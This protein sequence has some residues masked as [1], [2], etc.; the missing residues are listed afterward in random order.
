M[1]VRNP[2]L[3]EMRSGLGLESLEIQN[4][5]CCH[6]RIKMS[7]DHSLPPSS[8]SSTARLPPDHTVLAQHPSIP[9]PNPNPSPD[10]AAKT[11]VIPAMDRNSVKNVPVNHPRLRRGNSIRQ[12]LRQGSHLARRKS[13]GFPRSNSIASIAD[14]SSAV[15]WTNLVNPRKSLVCRSSSSFWEPSLELSCPKSAG[16][17]GQ[18]A[19]QHA[20]ETKF[21][22]L[23]IVPIEIILEILEHLDGACA[24]FSSL[25]GHPIRPSRLLPFHPTPPQKIKLIPQQKIHIA[26]TLHRLSISS[27]HFRD[28]VSSSPLA[29]FNQYR[30][31]VDDLTTNNDWRFGFTGG[32]QFINDKSQFLHVLSGTLHGR[33]S[34]DEAMNQRQQ[35]IELDGVRNIENTSK[36]VKL[37][38]AN[39]WK[40]CHFDLDLQI[41]PRLTLRARRFN[42]STQT[43]FITTPAPAAFATPISP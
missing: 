9:I 8:S 14:S 17:F 2:R 11:P 26:E 16:N 33:E 29:W 39:G 43:S 15:L 22:V 19:F 10:C 40:V 4:R 23:S 30:A 41:K 37:L 36:L 3:G 12:P 18:V 31:L 35:E 13:S 27:V 34:F 24:P 20:F 1:P 42:I 6:G 32:V 21:G 25:P 28:L 7:M 5:S 38:D